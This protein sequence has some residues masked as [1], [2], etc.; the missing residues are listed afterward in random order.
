MHV[1]V[2]ACLWYHI[3]YGFVRTGRPP[4]FKLYPNR[5]LKYIFIVSSNFCVPSLLLH[6]IAPSDV[7]VLLA[8]Y[9]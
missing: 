9:R 1:R 2:F 8:C 4:K 6:I 7:T 3:G 5:T